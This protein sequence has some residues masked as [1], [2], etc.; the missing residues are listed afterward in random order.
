MET[1]LPLG[2]PS[3]G[4]ARW[5]S[6][7]SISSPPVPRFPSFSSLHPHPYFIS[8]MHYSTIGYTV[9]RFIMNHLINRIPWGRDAF[10][11][12]VWLAALAMAVVYAFVRYHE[13]G[14]PLSS[15][16][17]AYALFPSFCVRAESLLDVGL[18]GC[19]SQSYTASETALTT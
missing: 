3:F 19:P 1:F 2:S 11:S 18:L 16:T 7:G 9:H 5:R 8:A 17:I 12:M 14:S 6:N 15:Q 10:F 4:K 13:A